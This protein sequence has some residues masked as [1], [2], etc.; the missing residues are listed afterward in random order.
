MA[1]VAHGSYVHRVVAACAGV[2]VVKL[3]LQLQNELGR[4][5]V[6]G[7]KP[8]GMIGTGVGVLRHEGPRALY[9]GLSAAVIRQAV[10]GG[11]GLGFYQPV[12][13]VRLC[14]AVLPARVPLPDVSVL[15]TL[16]SAGTL[17]R[18]ANQTKRRSIS[19]SLLAARPAASASWL[20]VPLTWSRCACKRTDD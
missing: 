20:Q 6:P 19:A 12:R 18:V 4:S 3:R 16:L 13:C 15:G 5:L 11:I 2:A 9:R 7:A 1:L 10:Y 17:S 8:K 14:L